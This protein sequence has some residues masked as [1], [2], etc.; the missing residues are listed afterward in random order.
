MQGQ[1]LDLETGLH[2]NRFRYY[3]PG[4]GRYVTQDPIGL[5]GGLNKFLYPVNPI[6]WVDPLGLK[7]RM[8]CRKIPSLPASHCAIETIDDNTGA[9]KTTGLF[10]GGIAGAPDSGN[11]SCALI[12]TNHRFDTD[13]GG[14]D[15]NCG[16]WKSGQDDCVTNAAA[17]YQN[18]SVYS[19][20]LGPNSNTFAFTV[21]GKCGI[22]PPSNAPG[23]GGAWGSSGSP[24]NA[25]PGSTPTPG[26]QLS[27]PPTTCPAKPPP[28][29]QDFYAG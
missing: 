5:G 13:A 20:V 28:A 16:E 9:R 26:P 2:Y 10:G 14:D 12:Y 22:S 7:S 19:A 15:T 8:C 27:Y 24:A 4:S 11:S 25:Y 17:N 21:A 6:S 29:P 23:L 1:Q 3:D 18:P